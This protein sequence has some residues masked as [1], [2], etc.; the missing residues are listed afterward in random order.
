[1]IKG[2]LKAGHKFERIKNIY[3][4]NQKYKCGYDYYE[5]I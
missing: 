5:L 4:S 1:M 2:L 3:S